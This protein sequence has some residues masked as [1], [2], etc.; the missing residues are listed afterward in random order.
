MKNIVLVM[1]FLSTCLLAHHSWGQEKR[2]TFLN[3]EFGVAPILGRVPDLPYI[4]GEYAD[5][6]GEG[7]AH[8]LTGLVSSIHGGVAAEF[9]SKND[10]FRWA[11]GLRYKRTTSTLQRTPFSFS[12]KYFYVIG[13]ETETT[14]EYFRVKEISQKSEYLGLETDLRFFPFGRHLFTIY[15][16]GGIEIDYHLKSSTSAVFHNSSMNQFQDVVDQRV[17][18]PQDLMAIFHSAGGVEIGKKSDF[19]FR[20]ELGPSIFLTDQSSGLVSSV[21][22]FNIMFGVQLAL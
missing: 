17:S 21:A 12:N 6:S 8:D 3:L 22:G 13:N 2:K 16:K 10:K 15:F 14:T 5:H 9:Q 11:A 1:L 20:F 4:R 19:R 18:S 7:A